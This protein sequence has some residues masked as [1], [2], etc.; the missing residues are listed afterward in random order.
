MPTQCRSP[1]AGWNE[2]LAKSVFGKKSIISPKYDTL[3]PSLGTTFEIDQRSK[4][5]ISLGIIQIFPGLC[6]R[7]CEMAKI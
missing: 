1:K 4:T 3:D 2:M 7:L 6:R 5:Y